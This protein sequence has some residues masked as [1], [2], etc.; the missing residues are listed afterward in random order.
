MR[1]AVKPPQEEQVF[2][3]I[4][5]GNRLVTWIAHE[6]ALQSDF[7]IDLRDLTLELQVM[8]LVLVTWK[9]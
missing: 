8:W 4:N 1:L 9:S 3:S 5:T 6:L 7:K 2:V